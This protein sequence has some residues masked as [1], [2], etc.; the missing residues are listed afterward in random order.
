M[1][2]NDDPMANSKIENNT[3]IMGI[4]LLSY[5]LKTLKLMMNIMNLSYFLGILWY[6]LCVAEEDFILDTRFW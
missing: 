5:L 1:V 3:Q 4:V 6:I 2:K